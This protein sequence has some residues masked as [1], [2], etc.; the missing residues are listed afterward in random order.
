MDHQKKLDFVL[1]MTKH[2]LDATQHFDG[3]G[4]ALPMTPGAM[5]QTPVVQA[6]T[7]APAALPQAT[8][9]SAN[10]LTPAV[11]G[12]GNPLGI[13]GAVG[14]AYNSVLGAGANA[15]QNTVNGIGGIAQGLGS[16]LTVQNGYQAGLAPTTQ[17][18]YTAPANSALQKLGQGYGQ[19]QGLLGDQQRLA[20]TLES[21]V[22][23]GGPSPAQAQLNK[24]TGQNIAQSAAIAA[25]TRGAG[26][27]AGLIA[28]NAAQ[29]GAN[30]QQNEI[31]QAAT[32]R[33]QEQLQAQGQ[34]QAEQ[35]AEQSN[36][37]GEQGVQ[38]NL[39]G[40]NI[41]ANTAQNNTNVSNY[42]MAQGINSKVAQDNASAVNKTT[43]G[44]LQ[45]IGGALSLFAQ[46]GEVHPPHLHK[47]A[48]IYYPHLYADGGSVDF[49]V[50]SPT[51]PSVN[52]TNEAAPSSDD[53]GSGGA[54][55]AAGQGISA[56]MESMSQGGKIGQK[57]KAGGKVPGKPKVDHDAYKNDTVSAKLSPG[58]VVIDLNTLKDKGKL[59]QMARFVAAN[60]ERKKAGRKL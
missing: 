44:L 24:A 28:S 53:S 12:L 6:T 49:G 43:G 59:G 27:N 5:P 50:P 23:G 35:A 45:G 46:G 29:Q 34:L 58:E 26:S 57:L 19:T 33:A 18:D 10:S 51:A 31:G 41:N 3:G 39:Y 54:G 56:L 52:I 47:M 7:P 48:K 25:G 2:G 60:I 8:T 55:A 17:Q 14:G 42:G 4:T 16:A 38:G 40:A 32:L 36:I 30:I 22:N 20:G 37:Q 15:L 1:K 13:G 9:T 21:E 11:Q